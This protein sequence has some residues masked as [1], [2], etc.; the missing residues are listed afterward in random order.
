MFGT[1]RH[2]G[3]AWGLVELFLQ[4]PDLGEEGADDGLRF[5]RLA[6]NQLFG[7]LQRHALHVGEKQASGQTDSQKTS[8]R[9][10]A[11]YGV[12]PVSVMEILKKL[13]PAW[14]PVACFYASLD[15]EEE[16]TS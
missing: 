10:V 7:D 12:Q 2:G 15:K 3:I 16:T 5:R 6:G 13:H 1:G 9:T 4:L 11:E 14:S 8:L